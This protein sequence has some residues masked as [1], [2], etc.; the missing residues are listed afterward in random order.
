M[1]N[2][3][4]FVATLILINGSTTRA[5]AW[6]GYADVEHPFLSIGAGI[7]QYQ[8]DSICQQKYG[9]LINSSFNSGA[10]VGNNNNDGWNWDWNITANPVNAYDGKEISGA[11]HVWYHQ[12]RGHCVANK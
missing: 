6:G 3:L 8:G 2:F 5:N 4:F 10:S 9:E 12:L 7:D 11:W 1:K